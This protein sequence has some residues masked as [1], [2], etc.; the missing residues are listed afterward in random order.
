[1]RRNPTVELPTGKYPER[2][3]SV[4]AAP[5]R[6]WK[7]GGGANAGNIDPTGSIPPAT[8]VDGAGAFASGSFRTFLPR[9]RGAP[10]QSRQRFSFALVCSRME[11][12]M[13]GWR[14]VGL[15][16]GSG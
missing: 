4:C 6:N 2:N 5:N 7:P 3:S 12:V 1:M 14:T 16:E 13:E 10:V 11:R 9:A 8:G 15:N